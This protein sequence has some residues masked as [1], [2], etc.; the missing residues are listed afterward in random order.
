[1]E[2]LYQ[3]A[4]VNI[5]LLREPI[6]SRL[7]EDFVAELDHVNAEADSA[8]GF[9]W[10]LQ[11]E[12]GDAT[13]VRAFGDDRFIVNMSVW[14]SVEALADFVYRN[15]PHRAVLRKRNKWF[16]RIEESH[17]ALWW[18]PKGHIPSVQEAEERMTFLRSHG[19][20]PIA[21]T[22]KARFGPPVS[23]PIASENEWFCPA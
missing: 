3:L 12:D 16:H 23:E 6:D 19:P 8:P 14:E 11:T 4:Q 7:L 22:F 20:S 5:A 17:V 13:S 1:M 9:V 18:I 2:G 21:F 15:G 10:R